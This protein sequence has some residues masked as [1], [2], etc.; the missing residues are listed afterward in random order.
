MTTF[1]LVRRGE[2]TYEPIDERK[3]IGLGRELAPLTSIGIKGVIETA[4]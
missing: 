1:Y 3:F 4:K 2:P